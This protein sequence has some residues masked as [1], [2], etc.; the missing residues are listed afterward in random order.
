[1]HSEEVQDPNLE[2]VYTIR[3]FKNT[4]TSGDQYIPK[5]VDEVAD[6]HAID[7]DRKR[8]AIVQRTT[9]KRRLTLDRSILITIEEPL[10]N[11]EY[12]KTSELIGVGM[13]ITDATL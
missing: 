10:I 9:K 12:A 1:M 4:L 6:M 11:I 7:Y 8:K 3:S 13:E 2:Q 5:P